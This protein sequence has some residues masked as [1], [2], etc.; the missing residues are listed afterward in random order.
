MHHLLICRSCDGG[1]QGMA[2]RLQAGLGPAWRVSHVDCMGGCARAGT[3][4][5]RAEGKASYLFGD[6][7]PDTPLAD[8][9]AFARMYQAT[10]DGWITDARSLGTLRTGAI[11]R[12]PA[13][14]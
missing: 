3:I 1:A 6:I 5:F 11:A 8:L 12:I 4:A 7:R 9:L 14:E 13:V 2:L 10:P